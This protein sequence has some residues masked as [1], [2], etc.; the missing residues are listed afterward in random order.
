MI[1]TK[2]PRHEDF[3]QALGILIHTLD[4]GETAETILK[5]SQVPYVSGIETGT[6]L[7]TLALSWFEKSIAA[8]LD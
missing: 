1:A 8:L 6:D 5:V 4:H 7:C 2:T 3:G